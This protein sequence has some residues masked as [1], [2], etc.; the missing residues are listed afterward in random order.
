MLI[1]RAWAT[2]DS[3]SLCFACDWEKCHLNLVISI[4]LNAYF[5]FSFK[6]GITKH[7]KVTSKSKPSSIVCHVNDSYEEDI[8]I[9]II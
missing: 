3:T 7:L 8:L 4:N 5:F 2:C 9:H 1:F 6:R